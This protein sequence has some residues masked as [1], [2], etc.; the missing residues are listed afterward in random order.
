MA[1]GQIATGIRGDN[2]SFQLQVIFWRDDEDVC[3]VLHQNALRDFFSASSLK[4]QSEGSHDA[5]LRY[6]IP[7]SSKPIFPLPP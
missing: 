7:I 5:P 3:F 2:R 1:Y 4:Q 6:I